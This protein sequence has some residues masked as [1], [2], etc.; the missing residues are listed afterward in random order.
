MIF[1]DELDGLCRKRVSTEEDYTRRMKTELLRE[2]ENATQSNI[3]LLCATNCPWELDS[4]FLRRFQKRA[5]IPLPD[6]LYS[7]FCL[8]CVQD[9]SLETET[10]RL[11]N[12]TYALAL[13][14]MHTH[15][16][17]RLIELRFS[18]ALVTKFRRRCRRPTEN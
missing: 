14:Y 15:S 13:T 18:V 1:I 16:A 10:V 8:R 9:C 17:V 3:F 12:D 4:A 7:K 2:I 11:R 5:F 6:R